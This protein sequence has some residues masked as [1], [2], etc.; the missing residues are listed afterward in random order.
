[1]TKQEIISMLYAIGMES[2]TACKNMEYL[3]AAL[4]VPYPPY[5][6]NPSIEVKANQQPVMLAFN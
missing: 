6:P 3:C 1:M 4:K 2:G 5:P